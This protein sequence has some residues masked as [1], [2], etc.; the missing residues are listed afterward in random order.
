MHHLPACLPAC[1]PALTFS[2][3]L[4]FSTNSFADGSE[5]DQLKQDIDALKQEIN[6]LK[7]QK[8]KYVSVKSDNTSEGSNVN[9]DVA[10][11]SGSIAIG[12]GA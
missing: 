2:S 9:N 3:L 5:I 8:I 7:T 10:K 12:D 6:T 1:L 4:L 11:K